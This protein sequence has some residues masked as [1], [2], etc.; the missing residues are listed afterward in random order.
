MHLK[1]GLSDQSCAEQSWDF[2]IRQ[3]RNLKVSKRQIFQRLFQVPRNKVFMPVLQCEQSEV[4]ELGVSVTLRM[5][6]LLIGY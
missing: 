3:S 4:I 5:E 1:N 2:Q 6:I